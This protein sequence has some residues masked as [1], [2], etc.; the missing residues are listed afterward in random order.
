[1]VLAA[2]SVVEVITVLMRARIDAVQPSEDDA[3]ILSS[4]QPGFAR[5][6]ERFWASEPLFES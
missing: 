2:K 6:M 4:D 5:E 1:M 3:V